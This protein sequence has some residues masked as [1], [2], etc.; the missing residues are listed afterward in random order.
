MDSIQTG[1]ILLFSE[2]P[3]NWFWKILDGGIKFFTGSK[4][5]H[6][7][8]AL[9]DPTWLDASLK[10]L[11]V[12]ESTALTG[13]SDAVD[14]TKKFGVQVQEF[15]EYTSSFEG[16]CGI[17]VRRGS[18]REVWKQEDM[19]LSI[20]NDTHNKPYDLYP[21]DWIEA[22]V[23]VGPPKTTDRFWCSAFASYV[24]LRMNIAPP[25]LDW[26]MQSP[27]DLATMD[28]PSYSKPQKI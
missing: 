21:I 22:A 15:S 20:Y 7:A 10:G 5:S 17:Y 11:Y 3:T 28:L 16:E 1:D 24:L 4:F 9:R 2:K 13:R 19:L 25:G 8:I 23:K 18:N 6:S 26:S 27:Q 12:W 14:H